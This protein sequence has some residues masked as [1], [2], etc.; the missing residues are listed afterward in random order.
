VDGFSCNNIE[1]LEV[2]GH[3]GWYLSVILAGLVGGFLFGL[4]W[5]TIFM[6]LSLNPVFGLYGFNG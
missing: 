3:L 2:I 4:G 6:H 1:F 5:I